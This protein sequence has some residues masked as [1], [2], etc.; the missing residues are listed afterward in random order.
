MYIQIA[1]MAGTQ[2]FWSKRPRARATACLVS[3]VAFSHV[4]KAFVTKF[5]IDTD[6]DV[7]EF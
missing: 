5:R 1:A 4:F 7:W 3:P 6:I 2:L